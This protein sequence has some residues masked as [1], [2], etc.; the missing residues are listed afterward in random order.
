MRRK[1]TRA[2]RSIAE[3]EAALKEK[4]HFS[5]EVIE[6]KLGKDQEKIVCDK[7]KT[8]FRP[9]MSLEKNNIVV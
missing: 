8:R 4:N 6:I 9:L 7:L 2:L 1:V 3:I 5:D